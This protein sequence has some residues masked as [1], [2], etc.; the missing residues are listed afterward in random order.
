MCHIHD[1]GGTSVMVS[2]GSITKMHFLIECGLPDREGGHL[3][4]C[5]L[6]RLLLGGDNEGRR[7]SSPPRD[8]WSQSGTVVGGAEPELDVRE[9]RKLQKRCACGVHGGGVGAVRLACA[10]NFSHSLESLCKFWVPPV[11]SFTLS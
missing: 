3:R 2:T 4:G 11:T 6:A 9:T 5:R 1:R 7:S 8:P 10:S